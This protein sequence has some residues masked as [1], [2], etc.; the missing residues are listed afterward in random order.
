MADN[1]KKCLILLIIWKMYT[2]IKTG[3]YVWL[4]NIKK[5]KDFKFWMS[6]TCWW[7]CKFVNPLGGNI[8]LYFFSYDCNF[9]PWYRPKRN[10]S[11]CAL[12]YIHKI[13]NRKG[14]YSNSILETFQNCLLLVKHTK[15][16]CIHTKECY[17]PVY[18][19]K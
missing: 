12:G 4:A 3:N 18:I 2:K 13:I 5:S 19:K 6:Y 15:K 1:M 17:A 8:A 7:K 11:I 14:V 9:I 16:L 10:V